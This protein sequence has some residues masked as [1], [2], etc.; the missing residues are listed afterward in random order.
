MSG[1]TPALASPEWLAAHLEDPSVRL[2]QVDEDELLYLVAHI[3][4]ALPLRWDAD[5]QAAERRDVLGAE[6]FA[7]LMDRL[8]IA[9]TTTV[10]VYGDQG[11][12][13]ASYAAWVL[14]LWGHGDVR[15]LDGGHAGWAAAGLP[16]VEGGPPPWSSPPPGPAGG[17]GRL[18]APVEPDIRR[19]APVP[20]TGRLYPVP[21]GT[22]PGA[23]ASRADV[24][25]ALAAGSPTVVDARISPG[26]QGQVPTGIS[27]PLSGAHR[28]GHI[29]GAVSVPWTDLLDEG[30]GRLRPEP[31]LRGTFA[32]AGVDL[33]RPVIVYCVV[34]A[35][36]A[37]EW[38][39]LTEVLGV[40]AV[41]NYDGSWLE[42]GS[43]IGL[44][45]AR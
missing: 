5:L 43:T 37:F 4:G 9:P 18:P 21:A 25:A 32:G 36:S 29:P 20:G 14:A 41:A 28:G 6:A 40:P 38:L 3:P 30:T 19:L 24:E 15:L 1:R 33:G 45:V 26:Y 12:L 35:A 23:R 10:V 8:G 27:A 7:R 2:L 34:G 44:P 16:L 39:V 22:R 31:E 17:A 11:N 13:W 42:W